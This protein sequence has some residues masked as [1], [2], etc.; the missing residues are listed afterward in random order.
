V[1]SFIDSINRTDIESLAGLLHEQHR[2]EILD[3]EPVIGRDANIAAWK[4]YF[5][6]FPDYVIYPRYLTSVEGRVAVLGTTTGSHLGLADEAELQLGVLWQADVADGLLTRWAVVEDNGRSRAE[7][8][9]P[10]DIA[11]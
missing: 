9:I 10:V 4:G 7:T 3:E 11:I 2:L 5:E 8:G 1:V 6:A